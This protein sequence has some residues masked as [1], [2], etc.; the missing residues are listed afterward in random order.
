MNKKGIF[1]VVAGATALT[2]GIIK[3]IKGDKVVDAVE[4]DAVENCEADEENDCE[5]E[6]SEE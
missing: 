1:G 4:E 2:Y 6:E 5:E 3:L